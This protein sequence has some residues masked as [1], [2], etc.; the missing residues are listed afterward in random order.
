MDL[1]MNLYSVK[2]IVPL[3]GTYKSYFI[4]LTKGRNHS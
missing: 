1:T 2:G 4:E 3:A